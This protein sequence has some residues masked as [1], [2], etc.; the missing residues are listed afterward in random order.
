L[1]KY[2]IAIVGAG[3]AGYFTAQ[4][5][6]K[7]Q[8]DNLKFSI[9]MLEKLPTPGGLVRSGV[10]PDRQKI[11]TVSKV[12]EKIARED[13]FRLFA[14]VE[15]GKDISLK[16]LKDQY[17]AVVIA[18]GAPDSKKLGITGENLVNCF[19]A[20]QF[21]SW[22]NAHPDFVDMKVDFNHET[23][24]I[25]GTGNV[26]LDIARM[27]LIDIKDL[28]LTDISEHA[29]PVFRSSKIQN[30]VIC[31]RRGPEHASFTPV[32]IRDISRM[33]NI[34]IKI[35]S[36]VIDKAIY[37]ANYHLHTEK[38]LRNLELLKTISKTQ[39]YN[40]K[41]N[42]E[43]LFL[44]SPIEIKGKNRVEEVVCELNSI[45][46]DLISRTGK[47]FSISTGLVITAIGYETN[48]FPEMT[49]LNGRISNI[50]GH[51]EQNLYVVGWA[52]RGADGLVGTLKSDAKDVVDLLIENL[53]EPKTAIEL[54]RTLKPRHKVVDQL[55]WE[56]INA[57]EVV[58]GEILGK[59]RVKLTD[60]K[61][62]LALINERDRSRTKDN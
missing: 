45:D 26:A 58:A 7:A 23:A 29:M 15:L 3:P 5:L 8:S 44:T 32:E 43:L 54:S 38:N 61:D 24:V 19:S 16:E 33:S 47:K 57:A 36:E 52:K 48:Y 62:M 34:N 35:D 60:R 13:G 41:K 53:N 28:E 50:A 39:K 30:I 46:N 4:A 11:K 21:V 27:L 1:L 18:T 17:D 51:I 37:R 59:P 31:G 2:R 6:Q 49:L 56:R 10:A 12:F 9:D 25:I 20:T 42:L 55:S 14:N 22:Y 40:L